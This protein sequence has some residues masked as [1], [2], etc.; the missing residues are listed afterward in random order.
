MRFLLLSF[1]L[2]VSGLVTASTPRTTDHY[3]NALA[4]IDRET[5]LYSLMIDELLA[6]RCEHH[7]SVEY[8]KAHATTLVP[9][10]A[11]LKA[12]QI[13]EARSLVQTIPC[14]AGTAP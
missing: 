3:L 1:M 7:A 5:A 8:L 2:T 12:G 10:L 13:V 11:A 14:P 4:A 9:V 6:A